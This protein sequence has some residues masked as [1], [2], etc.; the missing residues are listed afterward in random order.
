MSGRTRDDDGK[1]EEKQNDFWHMANEGGDTTM[2]FMMF[3]NSSMHTCVARLNSAF[4][5]WISLAIQRSFGR[6]VAWSSWASW[7]EFTSPSSR[8][9]PN[10][11]AHAACLGVVV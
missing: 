3:V 8:G 1:A 7:R 6:L 9:I 4:T 11:S 2:T 5:S 10:T